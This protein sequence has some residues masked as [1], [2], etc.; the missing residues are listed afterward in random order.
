MNTKDDPDAYTGEYTKVRDNVFRAN[1]SL[2]W[3]L[4]KS[5]VTNLKLDAS[6]YFNDNHSHAHT[7]YSYASEQPA[8]HTGQEGYFIANKLPYTFLPTRSSIPKNWITPHH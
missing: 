2:T 3:L 5:W 6:V 4:N 8:V 1:T 7:F